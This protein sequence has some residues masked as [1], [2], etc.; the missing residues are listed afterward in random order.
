[1]YGVCVG[2][3]DNTEKKVRRR[4]ISGLGSEDRRRRLEEIKRN[5]GGGTGVPT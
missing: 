4:P 5:Y 1:M 3:K 2:R